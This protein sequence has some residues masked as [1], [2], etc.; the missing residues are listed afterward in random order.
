VKLVRLTIPVTSPAPTVVALAP[1]VSVKVPMARLPL[2]A[3]GLALCKF[4]MPFTVKLL[5]ALIPP[6]PLIVKLFTLPLKIEAGRIMAEEFVKDSV[7]E[8]LL[9]S[10]FPVVLEGEFPEIVKVFV[11]RLKVP[12]VNA[13][14]PPT[15]TA[16]PKLMPL[17][18][19]RVRLLRTAAGKMV[20]APLPPTMMFDELPPVNVPDVVVIEPLRVNVFAPMVNDPLVKVKA[21]VIIKFQFSAKPVMLFRL[22]AS[23]VLLT[24]AP[25]GIL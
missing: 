24:N 17:A 20:V 6:K 23:A 21:R 12:L 14:V 9:A 10:M 15:L 1:K 22:I 5:P 11:A 3:E 19:F 4:S 7:A 16:P 8:L 18:R 2:I 13:R 25:E